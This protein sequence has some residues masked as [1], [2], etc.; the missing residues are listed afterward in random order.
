MRKTV[1]ALP[2]VVTLYVSSAFSQI[3]IT[4]TDVSNFFAIGKTITTY[5]PDP[6]VPGPLSIVDIG[7]PGGGNTWD[8]SSFSAPVFTTAS[9][10]DPA[11]T[12]FVNEFQQANLCQ[13]SSFTFM[14]VTSNDWTYNTLGSGTFERLGSAGTATAADGTV[15]PKNKSVN[16]PPELLLD[17]PVSSASSWSSKYA[18][19]SFTEI[20]GIFVPVMTDQIEVTS[21][22]D[23]YGTVIFPSG[24]SEDALRIRRKVLFMSPDF[25][26]ASVSYVF[27]AKSGESFSVFPSD[28]ATTS[29]TVEGS[30]SWTESDEA[31]RVDDGQVV[32]SDFS[33]AQNHPNPF[34]PE[35]VIEY[36]MPNAGE[37]RLNIYNALGQK[38]RSL[39]EHDQSPGTYQILWDGRDDFGQQVS[40]GVYIYRLESLG[41]AQTKKMLLLK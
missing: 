25:S 7:N 6:F 36:H 21:N 23:A 19:I 11:E 15:F 4:E 37:V 12:P 38:I 1:I 22:V 35:T 34:N 8:F 29:G 28:T 2:F 33:L 14:D 5:A 20:D 9:I 13:F 18:M 32:P 41:A 30:I 3:T 39:V 16:L 26:F 31:T 24:S 10:I 17:L 40:T 27:T